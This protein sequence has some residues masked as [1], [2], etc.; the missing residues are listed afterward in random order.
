MCLERS[1]APT[2]ANVDTAFP[3]STRSLA[4]PITTFAS[5]YKIVLLRMHSPLYATWQASLG[6]IP[7]QDAHSGFPIL[8]YCN[9]WTLLTLPFAPSYYEHQPELYP[10][11]GDGFSTGLGIGLVSAAAAACSKTLVELPGIAAQLIPVAF[12]SGA[13]VDR[14]LLQLHAA[15]GKNGTCALFVPNPSEVTVQEELDAFYET[16]V[17]HNDIDRELMY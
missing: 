16:I 6:D 11:A 2:P 17:S 3:P 7:P 1:C 10:V 14:I 12:R 15:S 8:S 9:D 4:W 5:M 13:T